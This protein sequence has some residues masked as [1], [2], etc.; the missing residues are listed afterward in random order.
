MK[1]MKTSFLRLLALMT[2]LMLGA[3]TV[4]VRAEDLGAVKTRM[5][6]RLS[7]LDEFKSQGV[8]GENNRGL[9]ELRGGGVDAGDV[10]AAENR[11]RGIVYAAIAKK[12]GTT[13]DEVGR[14]RA[15]HIAA[16]S[17]SG[18][19]LQRADGTWYKK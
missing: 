9:V 17:A 19:W 5:K 14:V 15:R 4:T 18:V 16:R 1:A 8:I 7:Q 11:D 10:V 3:V 2:V 12:I 6:Q 13:P